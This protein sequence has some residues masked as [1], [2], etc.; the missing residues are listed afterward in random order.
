M[1]RSVFFDL[2]G[3]KFSDWKHDIFRCV[4]TSATPLKTRRGI[5]TNNCLTLINYGYD[6]KEKQFVDI[7][8]LHLVSVYFMMFEK[9]ENIQS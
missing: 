4:L 7:K 1:F 3:F 9:D 5:Q 2:I 8:H 6:G